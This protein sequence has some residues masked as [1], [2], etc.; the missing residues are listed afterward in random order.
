VFAVGGVGAAEIPA[1]IAAGAAGFGFGSELFRPEYDLSEIE[2]RARQL[3][4]ALR[5]A[6]SR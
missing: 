1:W 4:Q 2:R 5:T 6:R 3:V